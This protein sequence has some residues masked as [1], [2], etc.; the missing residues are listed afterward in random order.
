MSVKIHKYI[1]RNSQIYF[2]KNKFCNLESIFLGTITSPT[3]H[4]DVGLKMPLLTVL[5]VNRELFII[6]LAISKGFHT[7]PTFTA[8]AILLHEKFLNIVR[9]DIIFIPLLGVKIQ[10]SP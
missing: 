9:S 6:T 4:L 2:L 10:M 8:L 3:H 5:S 7:A 1:L